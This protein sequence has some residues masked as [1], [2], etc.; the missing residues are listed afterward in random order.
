M[1]GSRLDVFDGEGVGVFG[2]QVVVDG[3]PAEDAGSSLDLEVFGYPP[4]LMVL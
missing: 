1:G 2:R 4:E 3:L